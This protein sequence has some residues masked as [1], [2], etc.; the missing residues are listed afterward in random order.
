MSNTRANTKFMGAMHLALTAALSL[1]VAQ[2]AFAAELISRPAS[3]GI[4]PPDGDSGYAH[5]SDDGRWV[6]FISQASNLVAGDVN[7]FLDVIRLDRQTGA[8]EI[9]SQNGVTPADGHAGSANL[10][11]SNDGRYV[12]FDSAATNLVAGDNNGRTDLFRKDM[13]TGEIRRMPWMDPQ[14]SG[15]GNAS[16]SGDGNYL[17][18]ADYASNWISGGANAMAVIRLDW[19]T[20]S[21]EVLPAAFPV[22]WGSVQMSSDGHCVAYGAL[23]G[24]YTRIR[25]LDFLNS[26]ELWV[27]STPSGN[28]ANGATDGYRIAAD[29]SAVGFIS[30]A[31]DLMAP[32][33]ELPFEIYRRDL[34]TGSLAKVSNRVGAPAFTRSFELEMSADGLRFVYGRF[35]E[36]ENGFPLA[37]WLEYRDLLAGP[38]EEAV[39][40]DGT[41]DFVGNDGVVLTSSDAAV[42][43]D[44][45]SFSD[46]HVSTGPHSPAQLL[47]PAF[48]Q[49][50]RPVTDGSSAINQIVARAA[51]ADGRWVV[52]DSL[53]TNLVAGV[54]ETDTRRDVYL[55]DRTSGQTTRLLAGFGIEPSRDVYLLDVSRDGRYVLLQSNADNLVS[56]DANGLRDVFLVDRVAMSIELV[57]VNS[58]DEQIVLEFDFPLPAQ[59]SDDGRFVVFVSYAPNLTPGDDA[60]PQVYVR[61]RS[62]HVTWRAMQGTGPDLDGGAYL[63]DFANNGHYALFSNDSSNGAVSCYVAGVDLLTRAL[64]CPIN[65]EVGTPIYN[66]GT[67]SISADGRFL[68]YSDIYETTPNLLL[69][70]RQSGQVQVVDLGATQVTELSNFVISGNGRYVAATR[71]SPTGVQTDVFDLILSSWLSAPASAPSDFFNGVLEYSGTAMNLESGQVLDAADQNGAVRDVYRIEYVGDGIFGG[72]WQGGME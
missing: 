3:P 58:N 5:A 31:T 65:D 36:D 29:C 44:L 48:D 16:L 56:N 32:A 30:Y 64:D 66:P 70:D 55:H 50:P 43:G 14:A 11:I 27:D 41:P 19:T 23:S 59:I 46:V 72:A 60:G 2:A 26:R 35:N 10:D 38:A 28:A 15:P 21:A 1:Q 54:P 9:V 7:G 18:F 53:A 37:R 22:Q 69:Q 52:F 49:T 47:L 62:A 20:M 33:V 71:F 45:N 40:L 12:T 61:D 24:N 63:M 8:R 34:Q 4:A 13:Q 42:A 17:V 25:V 39:W 67:A 51:G 68:L 6:V 57:T